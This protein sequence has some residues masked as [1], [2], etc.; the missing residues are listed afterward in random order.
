[1]DTLFFGAHPD[2][3]EW[4]V[5]GI[6]LRLR[7]EG[8]SFVIADMT[9][10]EMGS[11]GTPA[12]RLEE[13]ADAAAFLGAAARETMNLPDCG[14]V[15]S[16]AA[17]RLAAGLIRRWKPRIVIAPLAEDRHPDHAAAGLIVRN[18]QLY[19]ALTKLDVPDPPHKPATFLYYPL[20]QFRSPTFVVDTSSLFES[21]LE[22][23]RL[24]RSQF[25]KTAH[26][27]G[28]IAQGV[29]D[30]FFAL[31][32]RDRYFGSLA[33]VRFGEG[34]VSEQAI[35]VDGLRAILSLLG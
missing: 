21:K 15:D 20:H 3:V 8:V 35:R 12:E 16:P 6:A 33:G 13:A 11:R 1:V 30:Y 9:N 29:G 10:G 27:F 34:L 23:M 32:T 4:G 18:C 28:V 5:G 26:E 14:L 2:D 25:S 31:E 24:H 7:Q 17:R 22:L 19:C